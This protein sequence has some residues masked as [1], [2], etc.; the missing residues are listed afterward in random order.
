MLASQLAAERGKIQK[1][2]RL[3]LTSMGFESGIHFIHTMRSKQ[4]LKLNLLKQI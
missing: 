2:C 1:N 4:L 3:F